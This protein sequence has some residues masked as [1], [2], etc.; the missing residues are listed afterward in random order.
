[1]PS[2]FSVLK[3]P[4]QIG[5]AVAVLVSAGSVFLPNYYCS[6]V[7]ILPV[8]TKGTGGLGGL[9]ATAAAFGLNI[10]GGDSSDAN[11]VDM[12]NSRSLKESLLQTEYRFPCRSWRFGKKEMRTQTLLDYLGSAN[13]DRGLKQLN[14]VFS[15][16][17]DVKSK[18][19]I[20]RVETVSPE[21]SQLV[22]RQATKLLEAN[23]QM[24]GR[25]HGSAK[26][27]FAE[28]R[29]AEARHEMD[30]SEAQMRN[31]MEVNRNYS[32]STDPSIKL[33]GLRLEMEMKLR[34]Q[35]VITLTM[36]HEQALME[37]KNDVPILDIMDP[38][39][40][41]IEKSR[42][43]RGS[44]VLLC[45]FIATGGSLVW[46]NRLWIVAKVTEEAGRG[47]ELQ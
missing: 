22:A 16:A 44:I 21:L 42:P 30:D 47:D 1:M 19:I 27:A 31:F 38:G 5:L 25:T 20:L 33:R 39:N 29:L 46:R 43:S 26:A 45:F 2:W 12:L 41:P 9:A 36:N 10:G 24:K 4:L 37:E 14:P 15:V 17:R 8:E 7:R 18:V 6:E 34:Q 11:F 23:V 13:L 35:L 32:V 40:L 28:A 3:R